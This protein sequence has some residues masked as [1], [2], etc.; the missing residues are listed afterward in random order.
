[1]DRVQSSDR[2]T[3]TNVW[4]PGASVVGSF[5]LAKAGETDRVLCMHSLTFSFTIMSMA[6]AWTGFVKPDVRGGQSS[7]A[8]GAG[9][10]GLDPMSIDVKKRDWFPKTDLAGGFIVSICGA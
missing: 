9:A 6:R 8:R 3:P 4:I 10:G 5:N 1:M 2:R 7:G